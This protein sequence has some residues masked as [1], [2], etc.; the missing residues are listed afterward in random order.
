MDYEGLWD[1]RAPYFETDYSEYSDDVDFFREELNRF[2]EPPVVCELGAGTLRL[3][4]QLHGLYRRYYAVDISARMLKKG[5]K[6]LSS[7][8]REAV[9]RIHGS[10]T[11]LSLSEEADLLFSMGNS[12]FMLD[13]GEKRETLR[14]A[15][16][17][18][19]PEGR[20]LLEVYNP[21]AW[22]S[23]P[24]RQYVHLRTVSPE[25]DKIVVL[26]FTQRI[27][28]DAR[29]NHVTWFRE[30]IDEDT[31]QVRKQVFPIEFRFLEPEDVVQMVAQ[32]FEVDATFGDF[33]REPFDPSGSRRLIVAAQS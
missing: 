30:E 5:W 6:T 29:I 14:R 11:E 1:R 21:D 20:L 7:D 25:N 23:M 17:H 24:Q 4:R 13:G 18:L 10:M 31:G 3:A 27:D 15:R 8:Q 26:S 2:A 28:E 12:F 16:N 33:D 9:E 22:R 19:S 32:H